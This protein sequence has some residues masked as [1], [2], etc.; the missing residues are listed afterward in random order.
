MRDEI[1][2]R[3]WVAH[4]RQLGRDV[5]AFLREINKVFER[6]HAIEWDAPWKRANGR[7]GLA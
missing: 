5:A 6:F 7:T 2:G 3:L 4:G 1:D